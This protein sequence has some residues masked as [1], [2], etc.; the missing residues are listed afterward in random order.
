[1]LGKK[2]WGEQKLLRLNFGTP[3]LK[4]QHWSRNS[5]SNM[6]LKFKINIEA[7]ISPQVYHS[8]SVAASVSGLK[9]PW[10]I[11]SQNWLLRAYYLSAHLGGYLNQGA[12]KIM[13]LGGAKNSQ[14][15]TYFSIFWAK[16]IF[17]CATPP[18]EG[19]KTKRKHFMIHL[20]VTL[21]GRLVRH[22]RVLQLPQNTSIAHR[23]DNPLRRTTERFV[24]F[25]IL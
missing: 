5:T 16:I 21:R 7:Q 6:M 4:P 12:Q 17:S 10:A 11:Q 2:D 25:G 15:F 20:C 13:G 18:R 24:E 8:A 1:M 22:H 14:N 9:K 23:F 19:W 3:L